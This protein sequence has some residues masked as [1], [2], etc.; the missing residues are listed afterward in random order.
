M[1]SLSIILQFSSVPQL[2]LT[3][4]EPMDCI[5]P[6]FPVYHQLPELAQ[7]HVHWVG[8]AISSSIAPFSSC[9]QSFPASGSFLMS[10]FFASVGQSIGFTFSISPSNELSGLI[11]LRI[12]WF[13]LLAIQGT[14]K[15]LLQHLSSKASV[16]STQL[17]LWSNSHIHIW[18]LEK[19]WLW[20]CGQSI[21][22]LLF[23]MLS[24]S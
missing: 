8:D 7:I 3:L 10:Q 6:G 17:S 15:N 21:M 1:Q 24:L 14:L 4:C 16:F 20:L 5:T 9:L 19:P 11:S 12:D 2:C 23:N 22:S 18:L 13:D